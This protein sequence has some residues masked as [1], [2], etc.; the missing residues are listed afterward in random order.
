MPFKFSGTSGRPKATSRNPL[1]MPWKGA[2]I[3]EMLRYSTCKLA[4]SAAT[5]SGYRLH[6]QISCAQAQPSI[7][8][9]RIDQ[10]RN[11]L[12]GW[13]VGLFANG[14]LRTG[15][16]DATPAAPAIILFGAG[17]GAAAI[18]QG[19]DPFIAIAMSGL[20]FAGSAQ[21]AALELW[22]EP[23]SFLP[24]LLAVAA[25]NARHIAFG[26]TLGGRLTGT[27]GRL[28]LSALALLSDI[29]WAAT[30]TSQLRGRD[31]LFHLLGGGLMLWAAWVLGTVLGVATGMTEDTT[32]RLGIDA[33]MP[34]FFAC[35]VVGQWLPIRSVPKE[36]EQR[37]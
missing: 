29:N 31:A 22:A 10:V 30:L 34:C 4:I 2:P 37:A 5:L 1:Q 25:I 12:K 36:N 26:A 6:N 28:R 13:S 32:E 15:I 7:N 23:G 8:F 18:S 21:M 11:F 9:D 24:I 3:A 33:L 35:L 20:V 14:W 27:P 16:A 17:F 19:V